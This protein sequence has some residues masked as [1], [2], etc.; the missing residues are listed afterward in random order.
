MHSRLP[1]HWKKRKKYVYRLYLPKPGN[2]ETSISVSLS[3]FLFHFLRWRKS[4][5]IGQGKR[6]TRGPMIEPNAGLK[7]RKWRIFLCSED[8]VTFPLLY[9]SVL[10]ELSIEMIRV[11]SI[12]YINISSQVWFE[13]RANLQQLCILSAKTVTQTIGNKHVNGTGN[14][15][16]HYCIHSWMKTSLLW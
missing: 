1:L 15:S 4:T 16:K 3:H 5:P 13:V 8:A 12:L 10:L 2:G 7:W 9:T 11:P 14:D 6:H